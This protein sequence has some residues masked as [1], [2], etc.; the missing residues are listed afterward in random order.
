MAFTI[1]VKNEGDTATVRVFQRINNS[2]SKNV[3][4]GIIEHD[5]RVAVQALG[6]A[7][8]GDERGEFIWQHE[9]S[10]L[11]NQQYVNKDEELRVQ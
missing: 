1:Y 2:E 6:T 7:D 10:G 9:G 8:D 5:D 11:T 4:E 3:F